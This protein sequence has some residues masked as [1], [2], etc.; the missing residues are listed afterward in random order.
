M[1][2]RGRKR[3]NLG[4][5][6]E[7]MERAFIVFEWLGGAGIKTLARKY[8][9]QPKVIRNFIRKYEETG[10]VEDEPRSGR[11]RCTSEREDRLI[12]RIVRKDSFNNTRKIAREEGPNF[13]KKSIS[14]KTVGRRL[15]EVGLEPH[16]AA[17]KPLLRPENIN[18][19]LNGP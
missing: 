12:H 3:K 8:K 1:E 2:R 11:P 18:G 5:R 19:A 10:D 14:Y 7:R 16:I 9:T 17:K 13:E 4:R 15:K 6:F